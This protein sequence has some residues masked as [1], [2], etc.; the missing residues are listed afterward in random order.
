MSKGDEMFKELGYEKIEENTFNN[1]IEDVE[2]R[3]TIEDEGF[4][5]TI[6][7][8]EIYNPKFYVKPF[9]NL[10]AIKKEIMLKDSFEL[11]LQ[12]L[13]AINQKVKEIKLNE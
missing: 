6:K 11:S 10:V 9:I 4:S 13:Q 2:Y 7:I 5:T 12:E 8:I 3:R 1:E